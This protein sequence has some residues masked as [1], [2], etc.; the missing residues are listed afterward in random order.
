M[1]N[2]LSPSVEPVKVNHT[3]TAYEMGGELMR[4]TRAWLI[5][6]PETATR[7]DFLLKWRVLRS[8]DLR[9][10]LWMGRM[11]FWK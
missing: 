8:K 6:L 10:G 3:A 4:L 1:D 7:I 5:S 11:S 2:S 9:E